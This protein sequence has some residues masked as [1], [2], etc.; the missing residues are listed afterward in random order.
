MAAGAVEKTATGRNLARLHLIEAVYDP[1]RNRLGGRGQH[2]VECMECAS[3]AETRRPCTPRP[4]YN[5]IYSTKRM[6]DVRAIPGSASGDPG[7]C[8]TTCIAHSRTKNFVAKQGDE[9]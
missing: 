3:S 2:C 8:K 6:P 7:A 1:E 9:G 5:M 4:T